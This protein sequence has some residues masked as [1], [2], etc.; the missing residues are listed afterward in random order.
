MKF[1]KLFAALLAAALLTPVLAPAAEAGI[2]GSI[3][4]TIPTSHAPAVRAASNTY[5]GVRVGGLSEELTV[6]EKSGRLLLKLTVRNEG[7]EPYA[8]EHSTGQNYDFALLDAKGREIW[9]WSDGMTFTQALQTYTLAPGASEELTAEI[10]R[11]TYKEL[12][13]RAVLAAAGL[14]DT[15]ILVCA[16]VPDPRR[17]GST[18]PRIH[19]D[20]VIGTGGWDRWLCLRAS[21]QSPR[22]QTVVCSSA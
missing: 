21:R 17:A 18:A 5:A 3:G 7:T 12:Q 16:E 4:I 22:L 1:T 9:R 13:D 14:K 15:N 6:A 20:I 10:D 11:K 8:V 19:G 2:G